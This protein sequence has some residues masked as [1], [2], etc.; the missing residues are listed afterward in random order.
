M[1]L[2]MSPYVKR[3]K[4]TLTDDHLQ[5]DAQVAELKYAKETLERLKITTYFGLVYI[6]LINFFIFRL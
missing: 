2:S 6:I 4:E 1:S 3:A 5:T